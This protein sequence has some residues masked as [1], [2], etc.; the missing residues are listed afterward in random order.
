M[1][2][3]CYFLPLLVSTSPNFQR[4]YVTVY[5]TA[6]VLLLRLRTSDD[7]DVDFFY[8]ALLTIFI[9]GKHEKG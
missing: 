6:E 9:T 2:L 1:L 3:I 7:D 4:H 8:A 5:Y